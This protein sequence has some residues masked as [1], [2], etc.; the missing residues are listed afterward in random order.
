MCVLCVCF[1]SHIN[2]GELKNLVELIFFFKDSIF[3][4][5]VVASR[6]N[7]V[8]AESIRIPLV[9]A[10]GYQRFPPFKRGVGI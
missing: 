4:F 2:M 10:Q 9:G 6:F 1:V 5:L 3:H 7:N 8:F